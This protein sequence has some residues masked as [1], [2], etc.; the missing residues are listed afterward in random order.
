MI[1]VRVIPLLCI[2]G[3]LFGFMLLSV[4]LYLGGLPTLKKK[5]KNRLVEVIID[6]QG[7]SREEKIT[8]YLRFLPPRMV[9]E[10]FPAGCRM[11]LETIFCALYPDFSFSVVT[12]E[13]D[14]NRRVSMLREKE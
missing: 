3:A 2:V 8:V 12:D 10:V 4:F 5:C 9:R 1:E 7:L 14:K 6:D 11:A 13:R